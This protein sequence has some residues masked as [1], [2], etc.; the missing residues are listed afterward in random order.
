MRAMGSNLQRILRPVV[1]AGRHACGARQTVTQN[2]GTASG[3]SRE[4]ACTQ[5]T[6]A[7]SNSMRDGDLATGD[8]QGAPDGCGG[9]KASRSNVIQDC[10]G[11]IH[12]ASIGSHLDHGVVRE[13]IAL[14]GQRTLLT[15]QQAAMSR[16]WRMRSHGIPMRWFTRLDLAALLTRLLWY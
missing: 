14:L 1:F 8:E 4:M 10:Q 3:S 5:Q 11:A 7:V 12:F 13:L 15:K 6:G 2:M 9:S 16:L